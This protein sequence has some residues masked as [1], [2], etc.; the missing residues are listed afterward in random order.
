[1]NIGIVGLGL[2]GG[3]LGLKLQKLNHTIFGI[4]NNE[5]N[6]EKAIKRNLANTVSCDL[7][8]LK[9]C[10]LIILALPIQELIKP[11]KLLIKSIPENSIVTDVGSIKKPIIDIWENIHPLF[12]GSH[13]MAGNEHQGVESGFI[14]LFDKAKW[15]I[16]PT[17]RTNS[18]ALEIIKHLIKSLN[19]DLVE[20][21]P[22]T[23]DKAV[24][25]VSHLPIFL[26]SSL[27]HTVNVNKES[28]ILEISKKLASSGFADT[29]RV[30]AG[31]PQLGLDLAK[32][33]R[34]HILEALKEFKNYIDEVE[35]FIEGEDWAKL[36]QRLEDS[37]KFR[38][39]FL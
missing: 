11:S 38:L 14:N 16:T 33:N 21:S 5:S 10:S 19:C 13:P 32:H 12:V 23:H 15:V 18:K 27:I 26:S 30:G 36:Y 31:N 9:D 24:A 34:T 1:M 4:S 29:S 35:N 7:N 37:K 20:T 17:K 22:E 6:K 3:S 28:Q 2:I 39:D 25:E 8:T